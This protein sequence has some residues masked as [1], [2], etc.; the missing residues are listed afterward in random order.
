MSK[1]DVTSWRGVIVE[2][3]I[4]IWPHQIT[5]AYLICSHVLP[6]Y[7]S[8]GSGNLSFDVVVSLFNRKPYVLKRQ[9]SF[10]IRYLR[11]SSSETKARNKSEVGER[12][13]M[14]AREHVNSV[15]DTC[16]PMLRAHRTKD[17]RKR[18][19]TSGCST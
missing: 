12:S 8:R 1:F 19:E 18:K 14:P 2:K 5:S 15:E 4:R 11:S 7:R 9:R 3:N 17:S 16:F 13:K 10:H 6:T